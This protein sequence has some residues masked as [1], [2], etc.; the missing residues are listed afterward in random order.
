M[1]EAKATLDGGSTSDAIAVDAYFQ[2]RHR[3][4][5]NEARPTSITVDQVLKERAWE[6]C[7]EFTGWYDM[8]RTHRAFDPVSKQMVD[9][10]GYQAVNHTYPFKESD[11]V[12]PVPLREK[13]LNPSAW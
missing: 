12:F 3:A 6:L 2:V 13:E 11:L 5:P 1:W 9:L 8:L 4:L 7:Y 10:F